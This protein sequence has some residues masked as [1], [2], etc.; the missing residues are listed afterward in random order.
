MNYDP[1]NSI[2][3]NSI[4]KKSVFKNNLKEILDE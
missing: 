4:L 2:K 3:H 1:I